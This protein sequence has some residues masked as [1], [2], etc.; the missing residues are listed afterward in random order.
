MTRGK[1]PG[2]FGR[3]LRFERL[4]RGLTQRQLGESAGVSQS[5]ISLCEEGRRTPTRRT[6]ERLATGLG[7]S[8]ARLER[9]PPIPPSV[10]P[11]HPPPSGSP[12]EAA[13]LT[14]EIARAV[15]EAVAVALGDLLLEVLPPE[16]P[17][18]PAA[19]ELVK[20]PD[21]WARLIAHEPEDRQL[22][23]EGTEE[24]RSWALCV[25]G[26]E[27]SARAAAD[28]PALALEW[29]KLALFIAER[30]LGGERWR[31]R[32]AGFAWAFVGNARRVGNDL[33]GAERS[34]AQ[35]RAL[36]EAGAAAD[37]GVLDASRLLDLEASLCRAQGRLPEAVELLDQALAASLSPGRA[38]HI[39]LKQAKT[40]EHMGYYARAVEALERA[41]P[42]IDPERE[43]RQVWLHRQSLAVNLCYLQRHAEAAPL[44]AEARELAV[45]LRNDL[46]LLRSCWLDA[47]V[48]AGLGRRGEA[49]A[50]LRGVRTEFAAREL[51]YDAALAS[52]DLVILLLEENENAEVRALAGEM[53]ATFQRLKVHR[54][55]LAA[56]RIFQ[57]A[58]QQEAATAEL[59]RRLLRFLERARFDH[60]LR[61]ESDSRNAATAR[62]PRR[63]T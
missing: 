4:V 2:E 5:Q 28:K 60:Q 44:A 6:R 58:V 8:L 47:R 27:E 25:H 37:P 16:E 18:E 11:G 54:E 35:S 9:R 62:R 19:S 46:D 23:V 26:C 41:A 48:S 59:G 12:E 36:W 14:A 10:V 17:S 49:I 53:V 63:A 1:G 43:P 3:A 40:Y 32:L 57:Q 22:L 39:L 7:L 34:F 38:A 33:K 29:A 42:R 20:A 51:P 55:A 15:A 52:L 30:A 50:A 45:A 13:T 21:R 61:F 56:A 24:Y 31:Q